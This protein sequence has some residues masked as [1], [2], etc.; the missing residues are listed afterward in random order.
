VAFVGGTPASISAPKSARAARYLVSA[1]RYRENNCARSIIAAI[2][3]IRLISS[4]H[5]AAA[6]A[7][8]R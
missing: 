5:H 3:M 4:P 1:A 2:V 7:N 6:R 8:T